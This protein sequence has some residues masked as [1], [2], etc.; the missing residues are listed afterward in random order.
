MEFEYFANNYYK[1]SQT[2]INI[3]DNKEKFFC[4][5]LIP[6]YIPTFALK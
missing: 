3:E 4:C 6:K 2:Q 5:K 1:E